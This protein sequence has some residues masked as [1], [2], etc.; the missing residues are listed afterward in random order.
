MDTSATILAVL[1]L[2]SSLALIA[3]ILLQKKRSSG[4]GSLSGGVGAQQTYWDRNK[5]RSVEGALE[6]YTKLGA[7]VILIFTAA[8]WFM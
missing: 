5:G 3:L 6:R 4:I 8:T 2:V 1:C 7:I